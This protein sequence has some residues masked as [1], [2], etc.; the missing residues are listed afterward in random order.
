MKEKTHELERVR[1]GIIPCV[2]YR[3]CWIYKN[4]IT[5]TY[6]M[7]GYT[8]LSSEDVDRKINESLFALMK[9]TNNEDR[10]S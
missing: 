3:G 2:N 8:G 6:E 10:E 7:W 4:I 1:W 9:S 5:D